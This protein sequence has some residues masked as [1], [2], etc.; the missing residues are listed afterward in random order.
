MRA[1][2]DNITMAE[3]SEYTL[4]VAHQGFANLQHGLATGEWEPLLEMLTED[5]WFWFPVGEYH[6]LN[7]GKERAKAFLALHKCG[8]N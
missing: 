7:Q 5:F 1:N 6:G 2:G 3:V 8:M 4:K